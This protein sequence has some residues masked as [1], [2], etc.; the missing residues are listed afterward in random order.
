MATT[1]PR[2]NPHRGMAGYILT[3]ED[4]GVFRRV[5]STLL[6]AE[7]LRRD[8]TEELQAMP[9]IDTDDLAI[10]L[11]TMADG[12]WGKNKVASTV[13]QIIDVNRKEFLRKAKVY[14][15]IRD[16]IMK[17]PLVLWPN[18]KLTARREFLEELD[19]SAKSA[20]T[21]LVSSATKAEEREKDLRDILARGMNSAKGTI[22]QIR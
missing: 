17:M 16:A 6:L 21:M 13:A 20:H 18:D 22:P 14:K 1:D 8:L 9:L 4:T 7:E 19:R 12:G 2:Q 5:I 15:I 10:M 3:L 11:L